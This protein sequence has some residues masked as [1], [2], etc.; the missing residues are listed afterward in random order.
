M[1]GNTNDK[2]DRG[3]LSAQHVLHILQNIHVHINHAKINLAL[4]RAQQLN[5][6]PRHQPRNQ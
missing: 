2:D 4:A 5:D 3:L 1:D 6:T